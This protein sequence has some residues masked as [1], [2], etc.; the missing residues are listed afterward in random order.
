MKMSVF[1]P[2]IIFFIIIAVVLICLFAA[3]Y[4]YYRK[5]LNKRLN[6]ECQKMRIPHPIITLLCFVIVFASVINIMLFARVMDL[7]DQNAYLQSELNKTRIS[8]RVTD[9]EDN[10]IYGFYRDLIISDQTGEY[11]VS[12]ETSD[13]FDIYLAVWSLSSLSSASLAPPYIC[14]IK[15]PNTFPENADMTIKYVYDEKNSM[16]STG[17]VKNEIL[18]FGENLENLPKEVIITVRERSADKAEMGEI[19][20]S[21]SLIVYTIL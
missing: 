9:F 13:D 4:L 20:A 6:G 10:S 15:C 16:E 17:E 12:K 7:S 5:Y 8:A 18:M 14:Y 21:V 19:I 2:S 11:Q 1:D 3:Y